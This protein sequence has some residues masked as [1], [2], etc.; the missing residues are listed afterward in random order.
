V[1]ALDRAKVFPGARKVQS[2]PFELFEVKGGEE[3]ESIG[4]PR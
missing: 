4:A 2:E 1:G 3:L